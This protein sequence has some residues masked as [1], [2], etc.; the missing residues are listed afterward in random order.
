MFPHIE[1]TGTLRKKGVRM[2]KHGVFVEGWLYY[3]VLY[4]R[5]GHSQTLVSISGPLF[6]RDAETS[7]LLCTKEQLYQGYELAKKPEC[8]SYKNVL[9][10]K[11][12][13]FNTFLLL[14]SFRVKLYICKGFP[15]GSNGKESACNTGDL[16]LI[17]GLGKSLGEANGYPLQYSCMENPLDRGTWLQS[18]GSQRVVHNWATN[19]FTFTSI[20]ANDNK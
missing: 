13:N 7:S 5:F 1:E 6:D 11:S 17:P 9:A 8:N 2:T 20:S 3:A 18:T 14:L 12:R 10:G 15:G 4:N 19:T 16:E